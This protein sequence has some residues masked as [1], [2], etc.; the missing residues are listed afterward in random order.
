MLLTLMPIHGFK[1]FGKFFAGSLKKYWLLGAIIMVVQILQLV[2]DILI[3][4]AYQIIFDRAIPNKDTNFLLL[5]LSILAIAFVIYSLAGVVQDYLSSLAGSEIIRDVRF[6]MMSHLQ[7][8]PLSFFA[9]TEIGTTLAHFSQDLADIERVIVVDI[10]MTV[11]FVMLFVG[12]AVLL[13][14]IEWKL[15][16]AIWLALPFGSIVSHFFGTKATQAGYQ[17]KGY[18]S[19]VLSRVQEI[20]NGQSVIRTFGLQDF[21]LERFRQQINI[22]LSSSIQSNFLSFLIG[23]FSLINLVFLQLL[24]IGV[25]A[26][27][28]IQ[29]AMTVGS[30]VGFISLLFN[31]NV[32]ADGLAQQFPTLIKASTGMLRLEEFFNSHPLPAKYQQKISL[33][34]PSETIY[35]N[36]VSFS[37][38]GKKSNLQEINL[39]I[40]IGT[41]VAFVGPSGS[42]KS[43]ILSLLTNLYEPTQGAITIDGYDMRHIIPESLQ[44]HIGIAF[45]EAFLF[46]T[47]IRE[48]IRLGKLDATHREIE[49]AAEKAEINQIIASFPQGYDTIVG[50]RGSKLSGGQRQRIALARLI[51]H[52]PA[53]ILLD[54]VTASLDSETEAAI[55]KTINRIAKDRTL[56]AVT[57]RLTSAMNADRIFVLE[58]GQL[59]EQGSHQQLLALDGLYTRLWD[60]QTSQV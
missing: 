2:F 12:S 43:T 38:S 35:F 54:E 8:L 44:S 28:A 46:N 37:Y 58:K 18:D 7:K 25:G 31:V 16:L 34:I 21:I 5:I 57:H 3:P 15:A 32:A 6:Q 59:V 17:R 53:I 60:K 45:Q 48:N 49:I 27:F 13:F 14:I 55:N 26:Y 42:G 51:L 41:S 1:W 52:N 9:Q 10:P 30:L 36:N 19:E 50:E 29:G 33:S 39:M 4:F 20:V 56:I 22:L 47:T 24:I 40:K 11:Y 23:R